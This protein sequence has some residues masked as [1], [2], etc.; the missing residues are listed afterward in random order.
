MTDPL[1]NVHLTENNQG[2]LEVLSAKELIKNIPAA[3]AVVDY[4]W[5]LKLVNDRFRQLLHATDNPLLHQPLSLLFPAAFVN[6]EM[7][8][9]AFAGGKTCFELAA[10]PYTSATG[11]EQ[12]LNLSFQ[13]VT[14]QWQLLPDIII[15]AYEV[16]ERVGDIQRAAVNEKEIVVLQESEKRFRALVSVSSEIVYQMSADWSQVRRLDGRG[17]LMDTVEPDGEWMH[18][19]IHPGDVAKVQ[20]A[21]AHAIK[22]KMVFELEHRVLGP[23]GAEGWVFSRAVPIL[24]EEQELVEWFGSASNITGRRL[25]EQALT[26]AMKERDA[27]ERLYNAVTDST[28]DLIYV[29]NLDYKFIYANTALLNMWGRTESES[30]GQGLLALGYEPWHAEMHEREIDQVVATRK[31]IRGEVSFPHATQGRR[32]YDYIFT[33]VFDERGE[34]EAVAGTTRDITDMKEVE[35]RLEQLVL[36]RT[37]ELQRSNTDLQQFAHVAS[38]DLKEPVRKIKTFAGRLEA[39]SSSRLS[40]EGRKYLD[41]IHSASNRMFNMIEGVLSYS[42]LGSAGEPFRVLNTGSI[43]KNIETDL[44]LVM[45]EKAAFIQ[46]GQLLPVWGAPVLV[47]QL[48]YNLM[49]NSLK[50]A[51]AGVPLEIKIE[52]CACTQEGRDGVEIVLTDNGIGFAQKNAVKIFET[53]TRLHPKDVYEGTGLGLS[54]CKKIMER[55]QGSIIASGEEGVGATFRVFFPAGPL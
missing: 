48:F 52:S 25:A 43:I 13:P 41:K 55:H 22:Y 31:A 23:D 18:K 32:V 38:H 36:E 45:Q 53:F 30:I 10:V 11:V 40:E 21:I 50:F 6:T 39:D 37:R 12:Y 29:F 16:T 15:Y 5:Q 49:T 7:I 2:K 9:H 27:R 3:V 42:T 19:Y 33:P 14:D 20:E 47:L 35:S 17:F 51:K 54:L 34:V 24:N 1:V 4:T 8:Q 26:G 28:P 46:Y 44:E